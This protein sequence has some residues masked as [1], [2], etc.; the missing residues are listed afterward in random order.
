MEEKKLNERE[1]LEL[2]TRMIQ[3]TKNK[4]EV[5]DGN[6]LL[7]WGYVS[8]CTAILVYVMI[9]LTGN[10][11]LVNWLWFLIPLIGYGVMQKQKRKETGV[12][13]HSS[14]YVDKISAGIWKNVSIIAC[15]FGT[16]CMAFMFCGYNCWVLMFAYAFIIIG[17]GSIAQGVIIREQSLTFGGLFSIAAG[18]I[19]A[20]C[21]I[22]D[23]PI[24]I[25][26][27][28]P[29]YI[30]CF[31]VMMIIPGHIINRKAKKLCRKN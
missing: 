8:V 14:S 18:G 17:F 11:P 24:Y 27:A 29:L 1:S 7:I 10:N 28:I 19:V 25:T 23:I 21:A 20:S 9:M 16:I 13:S 31:I 6:V 30:L 26:W 4:L 5:G 2:I 3:E 15:L 12:K 22:C